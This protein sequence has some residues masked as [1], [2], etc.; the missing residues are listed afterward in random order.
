MCGSVPFQCRPMLLLQRGDDKPSS[1][2]ASMHG[3]ST[4]S[5]SR[6]MTSKRD[7][8]GPEMLSCEASGTRGLYLRR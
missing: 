1:K 5:S 2:Q 6:M 3:C 8:S 7:S 4:W